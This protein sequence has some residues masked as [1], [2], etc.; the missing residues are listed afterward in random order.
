MTED[1]LTVDE[2]TIDDLTVDELT[3]DDLTWYPV[4]HRGVG[5]NSTYHELYLL[6]NVC[7]NLFLL[8]LGLSFYSRQ[9]I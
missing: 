7:V 9:Q 1:E 2:L 3:I 4:E 6:F 5:F 8:I